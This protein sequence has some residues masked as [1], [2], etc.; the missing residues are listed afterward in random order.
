MSSIF[1]PVGRG[2]H[3]TAALLMTCVGQLALAS[4][5]LAAD[6]DMAVAVQPVAAAPASDGAPVQLAAANAPGLE[7]IT[8]TARHRIEKLQEVPIAVTAITGKQLEASGSFSIRQ[9]QQQVPSLQILGFN[10]RNIT[11][12]IR[13]LGTTAG[14]VNSGIEPGVGVYVN[15]V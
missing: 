14:T 4:A 7:E 6:A 13:G 12:Q 2:V 10:P 9:I 5:A 11:I 1:Y 15:G 3:V 8:V